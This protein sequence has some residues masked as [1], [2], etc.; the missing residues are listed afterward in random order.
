MLATQEARRARNEGRGHDKLNPAEPDAV[1][2]KQKGSQSARPSYAPTVLANDARVVV[3]AEVTEGELAALEKMVERNDA[4]DE[5]LVDAG[6]RSQ[7]LMETTVDRDINLLAPASG[8]ERGKADSD[9]KYFDLDQ[10]HYD[11]LKDRYRCPAGQELKPSARYRKTKRTRYTSTACRRCPLKS[12]CA[13]G[14]QRYIERT[15]ATE[16][17]EGL[18]QVMSQ[19]EAQRRYRQRKAMVEPVF[20]VLRD[21]QGLRRFRRSGRSS[22]RLELRLHIM[23]YNLSRIVAQSKR[24]AFARLLRLYRQLS[25]RMSRN[26]AHYKPNAFPHAATP[27]VDRPAFG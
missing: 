6:F 3:D 14:K 15:R 9:S 18:K 5:L 23:A 13:K 8:G 17:G 21:Q 1:V 7:S 2:L 10:F 24:A 20:A 25:N 12:Q 26:A 11:E 16:L 22:V 19:P 27:F 4:I